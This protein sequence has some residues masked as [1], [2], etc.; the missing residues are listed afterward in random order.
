MAV[1]LSAL[2]RQWFAKHLTGVTAQTPLNDLKKKYFT[3]QIGGP[4]ANVNDINDMELQWLRKVITDNGATPVETQ[5][6]GEL[7]MQAVASLGLN[8]SKYNN[9]NQITFYQNAP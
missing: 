6:S 8:V 9:E 7:W 1:N 3:S 4:A 5:H 2:Q